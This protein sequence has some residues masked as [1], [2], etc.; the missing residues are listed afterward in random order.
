[1]AVFKNYQLKAPGFDAAQISIYPNP[2]STTVSLDSGN[3]AVTKVEFIN[4]LG[5]NTKTISTNFET[6]DI[7]DLP[8]GIYIM[9]ICSDAGAI[10]KK[11]IKI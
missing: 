9:K 10:N 6:I 4:S 1:M 5:Q 2:A 8:T 7:S 11:I 3:V